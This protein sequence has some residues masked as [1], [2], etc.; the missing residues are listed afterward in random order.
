M[1]SVKNVQYKRTLSL[2]IQ[3]GIIWWCMFI[4]SSGVRQ[5]VMTVIIMS[6]Q[7]EQGDPVGLQ[8]VGLVTH[9]HRLRIDWGKKS[10]K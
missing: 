7:C 10:K 4:F 1:C 6:Q 3:F 9:T 5:N 8:A 2:A